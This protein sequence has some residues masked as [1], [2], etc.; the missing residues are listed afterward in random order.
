M[1]LGAMG[2]MWIGRSKKTSAERQELN[3]S[4]GESV[5]SANWP[6]RMGWAL[7]LAL[8]AGAAQAD[9]WPQWGGPRHDCV[10]HEDG[11]VDTLPTAGLLPR[12]W[13]APVGEGYSGPAVA[14]G[15]VFLTDRIIEG[16]F[17]RLLCFDA[18]TG[19]N[20]WKHQYFVRYT[21]SYPAGPRATP[22][23]SENRVYFIG[24]QGH[25][26]CMDVTDG[27]ILW[28]KYFP[29]SFGTE[30]PTWGMSASP[31]VDG[32]K[33]ITLVGGKDNGLL[34]CFN[35][36][37]GEEIWRSVT[38]DQVGYCP[39]VIYDFGGRRQLITWHPSAV[40]SLDPETGKVIWEV[41]W[42]IKYAL[43]IPMPRKVDD[44]LFLTSFYNGP[45]MLRVG[46][47]RA[48][49]MWK[50]TGVDEQKTEQLHSI[51]CTPV[52]TPNNIF[53]VCSYGQL[54]C[55]K[56][57]TGER[58]WET[59][60]ATGNGRWWNA[61]LIPQGDRYFLHNEQGDLIIANL[62]EAGYKEL[63]RA[64]L[65]EPTRPVQRRMTIWSHPAFAMKSVFARNDK[66]LVRV[67]LS[68]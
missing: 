8:L 33:L 32:E 19:E 42:E 48:E 38:D 30:L 53:G 66:E 13:S 7:F 1:S 18:E 65:V 50:G 57:D 45:M 34:I 60:E 14:G 6:L 28:K 11:I 4:L 29:E 67:N 15:R 2:I 54:R 43:T 23:V 22:V 68:K 3:M 39:P 55:L 56:T 58:V 59:L 20:L 24:T 17:E 36:I 31:L 37:T 12:V 21:V 5:K 10:W 44:R 47:D 51:M 62:S 46:S 40:S 9:D 26:F 52:V 41:P 35:K 27:R 61:F 25:L 64:K 63:S 49:I 16:E